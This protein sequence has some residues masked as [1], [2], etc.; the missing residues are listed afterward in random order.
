MFHYLDWDMFG[1][2]PELLFA[3][4]GIGYWSG[5][6]WKVLHF[7]IGKLT[8][9][10][11]IITTTPDMTNFSVLVLSHILDKFQ[12]SDWHWSALGIDL[13]PTGCPENYSCIASQEKNIL[14]KWNPSG[15]VTTT[16]DRMSDLSCLRGQT[17][18]LQTVVVAS[19][20]MIY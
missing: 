18:A 17:V 2:I 4:I 9:W 5:V 10:Q 19:L 1:S 6:S 8:N 14:L 11:R 15:I 12:N 7:I 20:K 13:G 16:P 3:L